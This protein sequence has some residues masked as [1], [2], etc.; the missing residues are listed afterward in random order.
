M[1][2]LALT[3]GNSRLHWAYF[4]GEI[5]QDAWDSN[6]LPAATVNRL[7]QRLAAGKFPLEIL[8]PSPTNSLSKIHNQQSKL[9]IYLASVVPEQTALWQSYP[10]IRVMTLDQLPLEGLYPTLGIDRALAVLGAG[11]VWGLPSLVIDAGTALT[12]T[13]AD[14]NHRL[15]GGAILPGLRL[16]LQSLTQRTAA[17]PPIELPQEMPPRFAVNTPEAIQSGVIYTVLAGIKDFIQAWWQ[18]F[19]GSRVI[20]TGGDRAT[21]FAYL[22]IQ[23]PEIASQII[24]DPNLIFMG[25]RSVVLSS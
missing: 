10:D 24:S 20:L 5:L 15:V 11:E 8:P 2:W 9:P 18:K 23:F 13:S 14:V 17:L 3:I 7:A 19:P 25:M 16:Q 1:N 21:L 6:Y 22:Q 12:F 4:V